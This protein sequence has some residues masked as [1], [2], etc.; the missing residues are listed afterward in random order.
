MTR[1]YLMI[2]FMLTMSFLSLAAS[3]TTSPVTAS[4]MEISAGR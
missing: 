4:S 3:F 2:G 1:V